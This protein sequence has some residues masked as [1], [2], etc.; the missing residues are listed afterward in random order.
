M[1]RRAILL[2]TLLLQHQRLSSSCGHTGPPYYVG[3]IVQHTRGLWNG[4][5]EYQRVGFATRISTEWVQ[6]AARK[7]IFLV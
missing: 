3:L 4:V 2:E 6:G 1:S 7:E 5:A